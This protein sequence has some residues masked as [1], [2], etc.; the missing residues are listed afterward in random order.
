MLTTVT[1]PL[2]VQLY[3]TRLPGFCRIPI[4]IQNEK[5]KKWLCS[6]IT[7]RCERGARFCDLGQVGHHQKLSRNKQTFG[8]SVWESHAL[9]TGH[10]SH[11]ETV[12]VVN[13]LRLD[14]RVCVP[15]GKESASN[16]ASE[17]YCWF[18]SRNPLNFRQWMGTFC[19][20]V[21]AYQ[22]LGSR[23]HRSLQRNITKCFGQ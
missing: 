10:N 15:R 11:S 12:T 2:P 13:D 8:L 5:T 16:H 1:P 17:T 9:I 4:V 21:R 19:C 7:Q 18:S 6:W 20:N 3:N 23:V 14:D 22:W